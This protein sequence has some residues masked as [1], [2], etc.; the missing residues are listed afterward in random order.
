M[1]GPSEEGDKASY[2][3][4]WL[5]NAGFERE[6]G[7]WFDLLHYATR[8]NSHLCVHKITQCL[9]AP[10]QT[11]RYAP[12]V[13]VAGLTWWR[14]ALDC[15]DPGWSLHVYFAFQIDGQRYDDSFATQLQVLRR[16]LFENCWE[17]RLTR[18]IFPGPLPDQPDEYETAL[19]TWVG[20]LTSREN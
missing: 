19:L 14:I 5:I 1:R 2:D 8:S 11:A 13:T 16:R 7:R 15:E 18:L 20:E 4:P 6:D 12:P 9:D 17:V 3:T 10:G